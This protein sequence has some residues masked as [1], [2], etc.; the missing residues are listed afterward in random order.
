[1]GDKREGDTYVI[2]NRNAHAWT[3]VYLK[4]FGWIPF[5]AT[6]AASVPGS[7]RPNYAPDT[8]SPPPTSSG[9]TGATLP[10]AESSTAPGAADRP[11][12]GANNP[13]LSGTTNAANSGVS[14]TNL[15]VVGLAALLLALLLVPA[16]RRV[17]LRR[18]RHAATVPRKPAVSAAGPGPPDG[19]DVVVTVEAVRARSDAHAA[20]DELL[21]TMIDFRI[22]VD[23]AE[24]PRVTARRLVNDAV[25]LDEPAAAAVLLGTAEERARYARRPLE[26]GELT[27]ALA[28]VRRGL[29]RSANRR[30]RI[31]AVVFPPSVLLSWR[32]AMAEAST[33]TMGTA[34]RL[35]D[36]LARFSPRRLIAGRSR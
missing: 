18:H 24:T 33:R 23:P 16:V 15:W 26:G 35:R 14:T 7:T 20:W 12:P 31:M 17:L 4:G 11:D 25:L 22:P 2:T 27:A 6:P 8:E 21:D 34:S 32:L 30:T 36:V 29:A 5:D 9:P 19:H 13:G 10:G 28:Q 3:E 1:L